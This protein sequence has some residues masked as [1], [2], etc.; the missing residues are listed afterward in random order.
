MVHGEQGVPNKSPARYLYLLRSVCIRDV[1]KGICC[2]MPHPT[3][4]TSP[5]WY[6]RV[7]LPMD[8]TQ[9]W[10]TPHTSGSGLISLISTE[11]ERRLA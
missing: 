2:N 3:E 6:L 4:D 5:D 1:L 7:Q 8:P 11:S 10:L 9:V